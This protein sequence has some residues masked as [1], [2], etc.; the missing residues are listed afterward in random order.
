MTS[1]WLEAEVWNNSAKLIIKLFEK[2]DLSGAE[3]VTVSNIA[4]KC[5]KLEYISSQDQ[6]MRGH[7]ILSIKTSDSDWL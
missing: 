4:I 3:L 1:S 5:N 2:M 6:K 7:G